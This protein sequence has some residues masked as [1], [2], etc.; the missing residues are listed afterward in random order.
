M[1]RTQ[2]DLYVTNLQLFVACVAI[3][4]STWIAITFQ[5]GQVA[6]EVSVFYRFLLASVLVF[7]YCAARRL[8]LR[9]TAREHAWMALFGILSFSVSYIFVYYAEEHIVSGL[10]AVGYS[11]SPLLGMLGMRLFFGTPMTSRLAAGSALGI[12]GIALVFWPEFGSSRRAR[13]R[14]LASPSRSGRSSCRP[15]EHDRA[16]Q[17]AGA[18]AAVA[19][20][21]LGHVLTARSSRSRTCWWPAS[22]SPSRR[23][24]P[25]ALAPVPHGVR[26]D[27]GLRVLLTLLKR[28]G[29]ARAGYTGVMIPIVALVISALF[30]S[31]RW[32]PLTW[33]GIAI[34]FAGNVVILREK[35][36]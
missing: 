13:T 4:G 3:W 14:C 5:L 31:F 17:P 7:A 12:V 24:P 34:S 9:H 36:A 28:I 1:A 20:A 27:P 18:P 35:R 23:R 16:S 6:P 26:V 33:I 29:A 15:G 19:V 22:P 10:V 21:R 8:P 11:A 30:E 2:S 25:S 32:H